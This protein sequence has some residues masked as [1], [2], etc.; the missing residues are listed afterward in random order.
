MR[1]V[2]D[3]GRRW[4]TPPTQSGVLLTTLS[5]SKGKTYNCS[6]E[7]LMTTK[8]VRVLIKSGWNRLNTQ[9]IKTNTQLSNHPL[10]IPIYKDELD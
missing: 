10:M 6:S 7:I 5:R 2:G 3:L 9:K 4:R 1:H 8:L